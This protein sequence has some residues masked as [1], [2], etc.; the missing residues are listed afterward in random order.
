MHAIMQVGLLVGKHAVGSRDLLL[1][2]IKTPAQVRLSQG[3]RSH[4]GLHQT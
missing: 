4:L 1:G 3:Q 2:L